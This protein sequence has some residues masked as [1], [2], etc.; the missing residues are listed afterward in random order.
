LNNF[1]VLDKKAK[2]GQ[3]G[4]EKHHQDTRKEIPIEIN[5]HE[6]AIN[7]IGETIQIDKEVISLNRPRHKGIVI[8]FSAKSDNPTYWIHIKTSQGFRKKAVT[9]LRISKY[10]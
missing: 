5:D 3:E 8:G 4:I 6:E 9:N 7:D 2:Q 10:K 1:D